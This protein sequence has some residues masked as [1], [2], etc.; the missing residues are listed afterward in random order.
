M[1]S[2]DTSAEDAA[3]CGDERERGCR[4]AAHDG[5]DAAAAGGRHD[6]RGNGLIVEDVSSD[7]MDKILMKKR[8]CNI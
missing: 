5:R 8:C 7:E 4:A 1:N 3:S 2:Q 6:D